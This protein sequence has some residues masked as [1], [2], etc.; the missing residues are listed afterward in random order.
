VSLPPLA[1]VYPDGKWDHHNTVDHPSPYLQV[2]HPWVQANVDQNFSKKK[3]KKE[4]KLN[5]Y[6]THTHFFFVIFPQIIQ[7]GDYLPSIYIALGM[8]R[9][10]MT[11]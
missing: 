6:W 4:K 2:L 8:V 3:K 11:I 5:L 1:S 10:P 7:Y 9:Q